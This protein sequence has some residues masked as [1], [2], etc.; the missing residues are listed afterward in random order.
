[1][2]ENQ[3]LPEPANPR[4]GVPGKIV[5]SNVRFSFTVDCDK[6]YRAMSNFY[7]RLV[8]MA[9]NNYQDDVVVGEY[10]LDMDEYLKNFKH[11]A[12]SYFYQECVLHPEVYLTY[13]V[14]VEKNR[15]RIEYLI[16]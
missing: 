13:E 6:N 7:L 14:F 8:Q 4:K 16:K 9:P 2:F 5:I 15:L 3:S 10:Q 1:M 11:Q 12:S